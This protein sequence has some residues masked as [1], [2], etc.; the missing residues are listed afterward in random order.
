M[1]DFETSYLKFLHDRPQTPWDRALFNFLRG[2][3][4]LYLGGWWL[5]KT[6][7]RS[8]FLRRNRL[9]CPVISVGNI[10]TGGTGKT[11][12]VIALARHFV[13]Q[14]LRVAV[15]SRGYRR[16]VRRPGV[17]WVS[18]GEKCLVGPEEGG[19]EPV[20]VAKSVPK[21]A[22][23]VSPDRYK[24]GKEALKK[25][26]P[27]LLIMDDGYQRRF[28]LHRDL[29]ILVV[30]GINPFSTG[31]VLPAG[32]LRE[33]LQALSEADV[34]ILNKAKL[35][36]SPEDIRTVLQRHNP[37]ALILESNYRPMGLR[38]I[39]TGKEVKPSTLD[40][41]PVGA[42]SGVANPLS[43]VRTLAEYKV[44]VRHAYNLKD[45]YAYTREKLK[46]IAADAKLRGLSHLVTTG[47]DEVKLP[48][49]MDL[50]IPVL[51]LDI[52]WQVSKGRLG[53]DTV[54]KNISLSCGKA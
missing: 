30:D 38:D 48:K 51:V 11:P 5:R 27:D 1:S 2:L 50:G 9:N 10:T 53:W 12:I 16:S 32:L 28:R 4:F 21:A 18:D 46:F 29:D 13:D 8:G 22:V 24:A 25:F 42:F 39:R 17:T 36:R 41:V 35:A 43:F 15:L 14:G 37:R 49:D 54:L 34:F 23:L 3:S 20:L 33:P 26:R 40:R 31:W 7:Y 44:L 52:D 19:D 47:K 6:F 45:H